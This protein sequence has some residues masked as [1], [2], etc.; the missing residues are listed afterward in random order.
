M[1]EGQKT[2]QQSQEQT[3]YFTPKERMQLLEGYAKLLRATRSILSGEDLKKLRSIITEGIRS[4][5][6]IRSV[7]GINPTLRSLLT[8]QAFSEMI[9]PNRDI[10]CAIMLYKFNKSGFISEQQMI[11]SFGS[12]V[13]TLALGMNKI[14]RL[15]NGKA[16]VQD[17]NFRNLLLTL[18]Q[19]IRVI[20]IVI[21]DCLC[22]MRLI[23]HHP[24]DN[25]VQAKAMEAIYLYVP[26]AHRLGLYTIKSELEDMWL[27]YTDRKMYTEIAHRLNQTKVM[28]DEY[29]SNFM[30]PVRERLQKE[31]FRFELKGRTKSIYSIW[32]KLKKF[33]KQNSDI[34]IA[35]LDRIYD[36]F[37]IRVILDTP[38]E[39]E[40]ADCWVVYSII[41]DMYRS[42][43]SRMKD[44]ITI[45]KSNGYESL[46]TTVYGPDNRWVE[47]QI[48]TKR[49]DAVAERGLAAHWKYKGGHS[50]QN[51]DSWMNNVRGLLERTDSGPME[52]IKDM[53]MDVYDKEVFVFSPKGDLFK[54]PLGATLLDF[55][56]AIHSR[57]G[58]ICTGG[59]VDGKHQK[60]NYKLKSGDTI[61]VSTSSSQVPKPDWLNIV[62][63]S[64][65]RNRIKQQLHE[66]QNKYVNLGR[67]MLERRCKN[68]K[69]EL[70]E[71]ALMRYIKKS[72]YKSVSDFMSELGHERL[73]V[74]TVIDGYLNMLEGQT[75]DNAQ[76][77]VSAEQFVLENTT[78]GKAI[79]TDS[80]DVLEIGGDNLKGVN[81]KL[82][83]C[84][85]PIFGDEI[86]GFVSSEGAI[87]IH[88]SECKNAIHLTERFPYRR[89]L[90]RWAGKQGS[91]YVVTLRIVGNDDI[92]IVANI[93]SIINKNSNS[94]LRSISIDSVDGLFQGFLSIAIPDLQSL[95]VLVKKLRTIK[96]VKNVQRTN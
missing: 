74:T 75:H 67:E 38:L 15:Y 8:A 88:K 10:V 42:N 28:R 16:S 5:H 89:I 24:D 30:N 79:H 65:A 3:L 87:K 25:F 21:V 56:F 1:E 39:R 71:A 35:D 41:V 63:T 52:L 37:A 44:Y 54:M 32:N 11:D 81:Y 17:E 31:G 47:V 68:R 61:E 50:E 34:D 26:L 7:H 46:H 80:A 14:S 84:C 48:R 18:A 27:K 19:D 90:A 55:A 13:A 66:M 64:K 2:S 12:E 29:M 69:I 62:V 92:D 51:F 9:T 22:L 82:A 33:K 78:A 59:K 93:T 95:N 58:C 40:K 4:G 96:G 77:S 86:M 57:L 45:P 36:L 6:N 70:E 85:N 20:L 53:K 73:D 23:N 83:K 94:Q 49:M 91:Q 72:G 43:P 76:T 60:I